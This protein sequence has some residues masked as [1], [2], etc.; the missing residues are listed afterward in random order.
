[1]S[2][3]RDQIAAALVHEITQGLCPL[4]GPCDDCDCFDPQHERE[5]RI[6][7]T[8]MPAIQAELDQRD[9]EIDRLTRS[10]KGYRAILHAERREH[11]GKDAELRE[12]GDIITILSNELKRDPVVKAAITE[13]RERA[14]TAEAERDQ[15]KAT[16]ESVREIHRNE[17]GCCI[18]C[19]KSHNELWPCPTMIALDQPQET[20]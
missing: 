11:T 17:N 5:R 12:A 14:E 13:Q 18:E 1:M 8:A 9:T 19:T 4:N 15:L 7:D 16:F 6:A 10:A 3:L 2:D 20:T